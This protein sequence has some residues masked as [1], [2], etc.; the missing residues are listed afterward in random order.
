MNNFK[1]IETYY[2][3]NS[4]VEHVLGESGK[5]FCIKTYL[6]NE[7][8][9]KESIRREVQA[10]D[11]LSK[12]KFAFAPL[13]HGFDLKLN[14]V[15]YEWI[16]GN[17]PLSTKQILFEV[18]KYI[19]FFVELSDKYPN[20][21]QAVDGIFST[22]D[23]QTQLE[24]RIK[25]LSKTKSLLVKNLMNEFSEIFSIYQDS[26]SKSD[27]NFVYSKK[28][29]SQSDIGTHNM[30]EN[31]IG[32][33]LIDFEFFGTDTLAKLLTDF[34]LHP[35]NDFSNKDL[36]ESTKRISLAHNWDSR[37]ITTLMPGLA[38]KWFL[39]I[40]GRI[41]RSISAGHLGDLEKQCTL[42]RKYLALARFAFNNDKLE[43]FTTVKNF[44][45]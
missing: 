4:K 37:E 43:L 5:E 9:I 40:S 35:R 24:D 28:V 42:A 3:G 11:L 21:E 38:L 13:M 25:F 36:I 15:T 29:L 18:E 2:G 1:V 12:E 41:D 8:R 27:G 20:F 31:R 23:L 30:I 34:W 22:K 16:S 14:T 33:F 26:L 19:D 44:P 10:L 7:L 32:I 6:G 45:S 39:I 17:H